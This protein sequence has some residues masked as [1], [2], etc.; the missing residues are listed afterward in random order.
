M[1]PVR[2]ECQTF[3]L[4][5]LFG[6]QSKHLLIAYLTSGS[7]PNNLSYVSCPD[8]SPHLQWDGSGYARLRVPY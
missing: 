6:K 4:T 7:F 1:Q 3:D 2:G 8:P 5:A